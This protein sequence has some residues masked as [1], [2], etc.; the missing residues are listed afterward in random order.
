MTVLEQTTW[1]QLPI[2]LRRRR[3]SFDIGLVSL[4]AKPTSRCVLLCL[5][6]TSH[7]GASVTPSVEC[8]AKE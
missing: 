4:K 2:P 1:P 8:S 6:L 5:E 7:M 3:T